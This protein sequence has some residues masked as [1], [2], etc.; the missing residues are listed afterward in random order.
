MAVDANL[1]RA[2]VAVRATLDKL[3]KDL[4]DAR[5]RVSK[6]TARMVKSGAKNFQRLGKFA[7]RGILAAVVAVAGLG[8][9]LAKITIDAAPVEGIRS[10]FEGLAESSGRGADEMVAA[11]ERGSNGMVAQRD[12]MLS[13]NKAASLVSVDFANKLPDAMQYLGKVSAATGQDMGFLLDSLV[14][15][16]GR[17][18]PMILDNLGIQVALS[19]AT[20][21][22]SEMFGVEADAL[23]KTQQQAGMMDV[24]LEKLAATT[25]AMPDV[26]ES[27]SAKLAQ[28]GA[29]FQNVKDTVGTV[30]LPI[31]SLV[32]T[33]L[34]QFADTILPPVAAF[35]QNTLAPAIERV[36]EVFGHFLWM[37]DIGMAPITAL[38][39]ALALLFGP[40]IAAQVMNIV[41]QIGAFIA[42]VQAALAPVLAW[43]AENVKLQDVLV[44]LGAAIASVIVPAILSL[45]ASFL[46][47]I[48]VFVLGVALVAALRAAWESNFLG[49]RD[50]AATVW[51]FIQTFVPQ[52]IQRVKNVV[53]N[54]VTAIQEF[55]AAHG[56][57]IKTKAQ[58]MWDKVVEIFE[59]F[60]GQFE[61]LF[62]AF[63][64]AFEGDWRGF[65]EKLREYWDEA[66]A[67]IRQI[68]EQVWEKIQSFFRD[69]DWGSVGRNILE[70]IANGI[71]NGVGMLTDAVKNAAQAALDAAK[72]F[73]GIDSPSKL[74]AMEIG[75]PIPE[76]TAEGI[77]GKIPTAMAAMRELSAAMLQ[78]PELGLLRRGLRGGEVGEARSTINIYG[79]TL[80]GVQ[81]APGL[82]AGLQALAV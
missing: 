49:I 75:E 34:G 35:L 26:S 64:T 78:P 9:A 16:V 17:V 31:L 79:L 27:A 80:E 66:W 20:A 22:A 11:L 14:T 3:D 70:G 8:A 28:M 82:L 30:F 72:G 42:Q 62:S 56:E 21:R 38:K 53:T 44:V 46:P 25:A 74:A 55:W 71:K 59:W 47:V 4:A 60:K 76:G 45:V 43:V 32:M 67:Q 40:E 69:T 7:S 68:G 19:D 2:S 77:L 57:E 10:A 61:R 41:T 50:V 48:A 5:G 37:L 65:G 24:V 81:D 54:V 18:S 58:E 29:R 63:R 6:A 36:G 12:L 39:I 13:Y 15:G 1:G 51:G 52:A 73:W 33:M 23:T